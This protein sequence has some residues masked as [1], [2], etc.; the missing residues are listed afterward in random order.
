MNFINILDRRIVH[1][2]HLLIKEEHRLN[3]LHLNIYL[4]NS[5]VN[6]VVLLVSSMATGLLHVMVQI[7]TSPIIQMTRKLILH[8]GMQKG[9]ISCI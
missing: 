3:Q 6:I 2:T 7:S 4:K 8:M 5:Q 1:P 9:S